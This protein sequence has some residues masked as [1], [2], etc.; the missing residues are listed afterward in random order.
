MQRNPNNTEQVVDRI[1]VIEIIKVPIGLKITS[2]QPRNGA[3]GQS[4]A[5]ITVD[6]KKFQNGVF[7]SLLNYSHQCPPFSKKDEINL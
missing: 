2:D 4:L 3:V 5:D 1:E 6:L 7:F